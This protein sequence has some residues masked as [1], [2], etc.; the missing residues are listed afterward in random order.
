MIYPLVHQFAIEHGL[1]LVRFFE[2]ME[3]M[4]MFR[5]WAPKPSTDGAFQRPLT[6]GHD[7]APQHLIQS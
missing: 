1:F 5:S 3:K 4:V 7:A 6:E 2:A